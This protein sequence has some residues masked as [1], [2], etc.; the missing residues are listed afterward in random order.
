[1]LQWTYVVCY[2]LRP[3]IRWFAMDEDGQFC[4]EQFSSPDDE[5]VRQIKLGKSRVSAITS[6]DLLQ[7]YY[8]FATHNTE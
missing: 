7:I 8:K 3:G 6:C 2:G 1:M 5:V 4:K